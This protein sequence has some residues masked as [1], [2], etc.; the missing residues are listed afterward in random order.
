VLYLQRNLKKK[1]KNLEDKLLKELRKKDNKG[2]RKKLK[3]KN[4]KNKI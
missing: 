2:K 4:K 1:M 3:L